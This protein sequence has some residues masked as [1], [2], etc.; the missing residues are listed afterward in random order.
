[1]ARSQQFSI[2]D[3]SLFHTVLVHGSA[4]LEHGVDPRKILE[5]SDGCI[6]DGIVTV[7][8]YDCQLFKSWWAR[9]DVDSCLLDIYHSAF[10]SVS[11]KNPRVARFVEQDEIDNNK[12]IARGKGRHWLW[13]TPWS[14]K[15]SFQ[16]QGRSV[17]LGS[18][19]MTARDTS[20]TR[21]RKR[22]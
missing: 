1:M 7:R 3:A 4:S 18:G 21:K 14:S 8:S 19:G 17:W 22:G 20:I 16:A 15:I 6:N 13:R 2:F 11:L 9:L 10:T 5:M 12:G